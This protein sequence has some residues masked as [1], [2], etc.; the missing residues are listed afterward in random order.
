[1]TIVPARPW[2]LVRRKK[3]LRLHATFLAVTKPPLLLLSIAMALCKAG[4]CPDSGLSQ[5]QK[6]LEWE[7][8]VQFLRY[9]DWAPPSER[10]FCETIFLVLD[11]LASPPVQ[12]NMI[13]QL[14]HH[15]SDNGVVF[16]LGAF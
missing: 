10:T 11:S 7:T 9:Y 6:V 4:Q 8:Q 15:I 2:Y 14:S 13:L 3:A 1:M 5:I 16:E 12:D